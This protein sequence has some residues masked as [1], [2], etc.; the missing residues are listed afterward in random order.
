MRGQTHRPYTITA[1]L[2]E[3]SKSLYVPQQSILFSMRTLAEW[4]TSGQDLE[5]V[6]LHLESE[7]VNGQLRL[8]M[9]TADGEKYVLSER[10][11]C[12]EGG[13][14]QLIYKKAED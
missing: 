8:I 2:L 13:Q 5:V 6:A 7:L 11:I 3:S 12:P 4:Q 9:T 1:S 14:G 10:T